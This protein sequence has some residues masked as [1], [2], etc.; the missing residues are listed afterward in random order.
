MEYFPKHTNTGN[1]GELI[2]KQ[3]G[4]YVNDNEVENNRALHGDT[5]YFNNSKVTGIKERK[6][7]W[8]AGILHLENNKKYGFTKKNIPYYKFTPLSGKYASFIVPTKRRD[9][10]ALYCAISFNTW[11]EKNKHPIG[12]VEE[13]IGDV[14]NI[15]HET[16]ALLYKN[17]VFPKKNKTT[18]TQIAPPK[19]EE[20]TY[21]CYSIDPKGCRDIDDAISYTVLDNNTVELGI[22]IA[23]VGKYVDK[24]N[25]KFYSSIYLNNK[26]I[27]MLDDELT[28]NTLS[29]GNGEPKYSLSLILIY[30]CE[31]DLIKKE[32]KETVVS[33]TALSYS[34]AEK[35][36]KTNKS[37]PINSLY[38]LTKKILD[39]TDI[40]ATKLVEHYMILYNSSIAEVLYKY[41]NKTILRNHQKVSFNCVDTGTEIDLNNYL[42]RI[43]QNAAL[44][45]N[46]GDNTGHEDLGLEFYTHA[47][48]PIRRYVDIIN[49]I[50][51]SNL[52]NLRKIEFIENIDHVNIFNKNLRKFYNN[53]KKLNV[54]FSI[55]T[56]GL[57]NCYIT[58]IKNKKLKVYIPSLDIEHGFYPVSP[59]LIKCNEIIEKEN[60]LV[61]N[62]MELKLY[63]KITIE[64][65]MLPYETKF[66]RKLFIKI[67]DLNCLGDI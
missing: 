6:K 53:Y 57:Y 49:Q 20:V 59:K 17:D 9:K 58:E 46:N 34:G 32:F 28:Y 23:H 55:T 2:Y 22:H 36:I 37:H 42:S 25:S 38:N 14:G 24:F 30:S 52:I 3:T 12:Q 40:P 62:D 51:L 60:M 47:T 4:F 66:N 31:G 65:T 67:C 13:Y 50:N 8:I 48:S 26:Q 29:L 64:I 15:D 41:D 33:N 56:K 18:F 45:T 27:N 19:I 43:T 44:Y 10:C 7:V 5:V 21:M 11:T 1:I 35:I 39:V 54:I 16:M 61:I 63:N